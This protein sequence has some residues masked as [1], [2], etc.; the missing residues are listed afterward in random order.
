MTTNNCPPQT[1]ITI[2]QRLRT[3]DGVRNVRSDTR[4]KP[5]TMQN[6][7]GNR[8]ML[9][10]FYTNANSLMNKRNELQGKID[11]K[12]PDLIGITEVWMKETYMLQGYHPA[13][14][15][16]RP[17]GHQGGGVMLFVRDHLQVTEC[18]ELNSQPLSEAVWCYINMSSSRRILVG[19]CYRSP[20]CTSDDN[21][22]MLE[23]L[24]STQSIRADGLLLMGDF[25]FASINWDSGIVND[26]ESSEA[27]KF[28]EAM[29][30]LFLYQHVKF[31]TRFRD[32]QIPSCL[33]LIFTDQEYVIDD[34]VGGEPLGKSDH[35]TITWNYMFDEGLVDTKKQ[36]ARPYQYN[37]K[38]GEYTAMNHALT[39]IDWAGLETMSVE[40]AWKY[41][42][43]VINKFIRIYIPVVGTKKKHHTAPW[44][45][46]ELTNAVKRK[47][48]A[49]QRYARTQSPNDYSLYTHQRNRTTAAIR[50]ARNS[51]ESQII[52]NLKKEPKKLYQYIRSQQRAKVT[53]GPLLTGGRMTINDEETAEVLHSFF[54]SVFVQED[55]RTVPDFP[56]H[57]ED[58]AALTDIEITHEDV[59]KELRSLKMDKAAGPDGIPNHVLNMCADQLARPL[60]TLFRKTLAEGTL[61]SDW[62][63]AKVTPIFKKGSRRNPSNF[64]PISLTSQSCKVMER[65]IQ[66]HLLQH[67]ERE[68]LLTPHQH[69]FTHGRSC[70]SNLLEAF[71]DWTRIIDE[72]QNLDIIYLDYRKA[73]D[74][75][76]HIRLLKKL[77]GYGVRAKVLKWIREFLTNRQQQ[78][79]VGGSTSSWGSVAS[80]VPQGS[81]LGPTLFTL[82]VNELPSMVTSTMKL[83]ADDTKLYRMIQDPGDSQA[84]QEDLKLLSDWSDKWLLRFNLEKCTVM[85]CGHSNQ[86]TTYF[87]RQG[88]DQ[89]HPLAET[90]EERDLGVHVASSLKPTTHCLRAANKAMSALKLTRMT[91]DQFTKTNFNRL[92]TTYIRPHLDFCAQAVGPYMQQDFDALEKVQRRATK[93]VKGMKHLP[94]HERLKRLKLCSMK[95]RVNRGDLIETYKI[96]TGKVRLDPDKFFKRAEDLRTRGHHLKLQKRRSAHQARLNFFSNRVVTSWNSLPE[97]VV[98]ATTTN[99]FKNRLDRYWADKALS[100]LTSS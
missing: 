47:Y 5:P 74:T 62:R 63:Q 20:S 32:G 52:G 55:T 35:I 94:Y 21:H 23:M 9:S 67:I 17:D 54:Q 31:P 66:R 15:K 64:R 86:N 29:Q 58:D 43:E 77:Q 69:G 38:K 13:F 27:V 90:K 18:T 41:I 34:I 14:R 95:E 10:C 26:S 71:E 89:L 98:S 56:D 65:I 72:G 57:V 46:N 48:Q 1:G 8:E 22:N 42:K 68:N 81:V 59:L 39:T 78:V 44:W 83:F 3:S 49:W 80:G 99:G 79:V 73:F 28:F 12:K 76:P 16:D 92:Y 7:H 50:K 51:F 61:P 37:Y 96:L 60:L 84:I 11:T 25:N 6:I 70:Q 40:E 24:R 91:F 87:M 19:I 97:E 33:D 30:D 82:Y 2:D 93:L 100:S 45:S 4:T 85:H 88:G 75:V 53:V 36:T